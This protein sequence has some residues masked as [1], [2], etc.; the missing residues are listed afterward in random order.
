MA[1]VVKV[2]GDDQAFEI[3]ELYNIASGPSRSEVASS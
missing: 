3:V 1:A 2:R